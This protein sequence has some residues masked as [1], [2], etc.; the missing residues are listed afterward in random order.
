MS[1]AMRILLM[2][3]RLMKKVERGERLGCSGRFVFVTV[4][5]LEGKVRIMGESEWLFINLRR[6]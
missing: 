6:V 3:W 5:F 4:I 2:G 1:R